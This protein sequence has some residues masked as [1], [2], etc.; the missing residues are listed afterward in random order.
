MKRSGKILDDRGEHMPGA[1]RIEVPVMPPWLKN[2][3]WI[4]AA[5]I[6]LFMIVSRPV[7]SANAVTTVLGGVLYVINGLYAFATALAS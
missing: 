6:V 3:G 5:A 7:E 1:L 2:A 4:A